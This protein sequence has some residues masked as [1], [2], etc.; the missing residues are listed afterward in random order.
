MDDLTEEI[1]KSIL[2]SDSIWWWEWAITLQSFCQALRFL[3]EP[4]ILE[5]LRRRFER[6][7]NYF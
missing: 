7:G 5:T 2:F 3:D 6:D 4:N 1:L